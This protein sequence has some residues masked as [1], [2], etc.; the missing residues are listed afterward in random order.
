M[1]D[2]ITTATAAMLTDLER[3]KSIGQNF[4]NAATTGYKAEY[5]VNGVSP[6]RFAQMVAADP[7]AAMQVA[8][9]ER[10]GALRQTDRRLDLAIEG[11][12]YFQVETPQ[13]VR[14]TRRGDFTL[15]A[16]GT[17]Q[18]AEGHAVMGVQGALRLTS[19]VVQIGQDGALMQ[20]ERAIGRLA[21]AAFAPGGELVHEGDGLYRATAAPT[22]LNDGGASVRQG[23]LEAANVQPVAEMVRLME[24]VRHFGLTAQALRANDEILE[25]S[26]SR[27][28][29]F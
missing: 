6:E 18:T 14:Y 20:D 7:A 22:S 12:G 11:P 17:L 25:S 3:L 13:G 10:A 8:L 19:D 4:A 5:A 2:I 27:L 1:S 23:Y 9:D 26:I 16:D 29:E 28:G 15:G 21:V 24:T